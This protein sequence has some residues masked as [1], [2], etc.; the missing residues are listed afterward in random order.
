M[1]WERMFP[2]LPDLSRRERR[3]L[4]MP[5]QLSSLRTVNSK[6]L[7]VVIKDQTCHLHLPSESGHR[8]SLPTGQLKVNSLWEVRHLLIRSPRMPSSFN[9][10]KVSVSTSQITGRSGQHTKTQTAHRSFSRILSSW[11]R[12]SMSTKNK[13]LRKGRAANNL[14][15][16]LKTA[17]VV[18]RTTLV[19][20]TL[21][22]KRA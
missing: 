7:G 17:I 15:G 8:V 9:S 5:H 18:T 1:E 22:K 2:P 11:G 6:I 19:T 21:S 20:S 13:N 12:G 16:P 4:E 14:R 3:W 10:W